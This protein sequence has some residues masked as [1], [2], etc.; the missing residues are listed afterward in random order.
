[1]SNVEEELIHRREAMPLTERQIRRLESI[2]NYHTQYEVLLIGPDGQNILIGYTSRHTRK[3][4][5]DLLRRHPDAVINLVGGDAK[6]TYGRKMLSFS[7]GWTAKFSGRTER[8]AILYGE[9]PFIG[10]HE[11][12]LTEH[13]AN[14]KNG[15]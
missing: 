1:M 11:A 5:L 6:T 13:V 3:G 15:I 4:L 12:A 14:A 2:K 9:M 8:D 10:D 7:S